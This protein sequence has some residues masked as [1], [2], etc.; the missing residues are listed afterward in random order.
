MNL[1]FG[2]TA[3]NGE[4]YQPLLYTVIIPA[5]EASQ[6]IWVTP[7]LHQALLGTRTVIASVLPGA[8]YVAG[9]GG[10][11]TTATVIITDGPV[12]VSASAQGIPLLGPLEMVLLA[13][14][15]GATGVVAVNLRRR[16]PFGPGGSAQ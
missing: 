4:D 16:N 11:S 14:L 8:G 13:L 10:G 2:G 3:R 9:G 7:I 6:T 15:L 1:S 12:K 5:Y